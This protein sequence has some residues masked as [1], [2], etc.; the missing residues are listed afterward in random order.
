MS[1]IQTQEEWEERISFKII[2]FIRNELYLDL[3]FLGMAFSS[4]K[5]KKDGRL[6]TF[7]TDGSCLYFAPE[8]VIRVFQHNARFLDR[9]YLHTVLHCIFSHLWTAGKRDRVLWNLSCDIAVEYTIDRMDK[10]STKRILGWMRQNIY[11][12]L[13]TANNAISAAVIYRAL[14]EKSA[15]EL[16]SL[17]R[18]FYTDD[19]SFWPKQDDSNA[20]Q[21]QAM[22]A[23]NNWNKIARQTK[24][25]QEQRGN[26]PKEGEELLAAQLKAERSRR[27]YRDFL[28]K[29]SVFREEI[30]CDPDEFDLNSYTYGLRLYKNM[31]LIEPVESRES[32]KIREFVI[33]I[34][35]SYST[36]G[37]LVEHFLRETFEILMQKNSFFQESR[38]RIIQ[39]DDQIRDDQ[40]I[41][42]EADIQKVLSQFTVA[43]G[44]GTDFRPVFSYVDDLIAQGIL[45]NPGG[46]LY[47]T[48]GKGCYPNRRP[49]YKTAFLFP[50][51]YE[52]Q[53]VPPW[54]IRFRV[55]P[56]E[57][58]NRKR[59]GNFLE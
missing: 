59:D 49:D 6:Q 42:T 17:D 53:D 9:V 8:Q 28:Q 14:K 29:F 23:R 19:H 56:E 30:H 54:A 33:A 48:D 3:R 43:G 52:E 31:P 21:Q 1:H 46:L 50:I 7:A 13:E 39:C 38:I 2:D 34:D 25:E 58:E 35:T 32:K 18:E 12:E 20:E 44:G 16:K 10:P 24:L 4:L 11:E 5:P 26:E 55:D 57:F 45:K 22:T 36:S 47:F 37:E 15:E 40:E 51:E 27:S 41:R